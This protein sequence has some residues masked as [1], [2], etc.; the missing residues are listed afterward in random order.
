MLGPSS[1]EETELSQSSSRNIC[2]VSALAAQKIS[3]FFHQLLASSQTLHVESPWRFRIQ[4]DDDLC[5]Y[6]TEGS[7]LC[8]Q[9][10]YVPLAP[11]KLC[12]LHGRKC[13]LRAGYVQGVKRCLQRSAIKQPYASPLGCGQWER[14]ATKQSITQQQMPPAVAGMMNSSRA[15]PA[16]A[17]ANLGSR[18]RR[19]SEKIRQIQRAVTPLCI[20]LYWTDQVFKTDVSCQSY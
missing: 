6:P 3:S 19:N 8:F 14:R 20:L 13:C 12:Y 16:A 1:R 15:L 4:E 9:R 11:W 5:L 18:S 2:F 7:S 17:D 10:S